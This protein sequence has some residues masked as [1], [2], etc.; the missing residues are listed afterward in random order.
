MSEEA[1]DKA[2]KGKQT[3]NFVILKSGEIVDQDGRHFTTKTAKEYLE[4]AKPEPK[5]AYIFWVP[6]ASAVEIVKALATPFTDYGVTIFLV[7]D[8]KKSQKTEPTSLDK[9]GAK[10]T[11]VLVGDANPKSLTAKDKMPDMT[12]RPEYLRPEKL[13][14][15]VRCVFV[16]DAD[17]VA[18]AKKAETLFLGK[19]PPDLE[20]F[21][22]NGTLIQP[23]AWSFLE[24]VSPL[25]KIKT[26]T[27]RADLGSKVV[28][29]NGALLSKPEEFSVA[30][31]T[32]RKVIADDG[33][34]SIRAMFTAE[35]D[36]WWSFIAFDIEEPVFVLETQGGKYRFIVGFDSKGYISCI[37]ELNFF[38]PPKT[39]TAD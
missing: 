30:A 6:D 39:K 10:K 25:D 19:Q 14:T 28:K 22:A 7:R 21:F 32:L 23:G 18:A 1:A 34:G 5:A 16:P 8:I 38:S 2:L 9:N 15:R 11:L 17:V 33:G 35:M 24:H 20:I 4:R 13:P 29:L 36:R 12:G 31:Q 3:Y 26:I 27:H 37:D